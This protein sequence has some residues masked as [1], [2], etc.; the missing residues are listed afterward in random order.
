MSL[1]TKQIFLEIRGK[2]IILQ[3]LCYYPIFYVIRA[4]GDVP[5]K[6]KTGI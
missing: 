2:F 1:W 5:F 4:N 3:E 6:S